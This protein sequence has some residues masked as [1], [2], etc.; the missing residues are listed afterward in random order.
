MTKLEKFQTILT[1]LKSL[2]ADYI[3]RLISILS[4]EQLVNPKSVLDYV[5][6]ERFAEGW[7]CPV[8][9]SKHIVRNGHRPK[10]N[11]QRFLCRDCGKSFTAN[12][13]SIS[14]G[15]RKNMLVWK[16]YI[17]CM[18]NGFSVRKTAQICEIHRNTAFAWRHK[19][20][21]AL[22][23][24]QNDV[25][26]S[27]IVEADETFFPVSYKGNHKN[28]KTF[29][30][31]R[32]PH[33]RGH[34]IKKKGLSD[35]QVC[36]PCAVNRKGKSIAKVGKLG[37]VSF[38]C[39]DIILG[40][41]IISNSTLCT[42]KEQAYRKFSREH[43]LQLIQLETGKSKRGIYNIQHINSYHSIL[44]SF[45]YGF[46]GVSTKYLNNYLVWNNLVNYADET[47]KEKMSIFLSYVMCKSIKIRYKDIPKRPPLPVVV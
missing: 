45:M 4:N 15:T 7:V 39:I 46:K 17:E 22:Q 23:F 29:V 24:M 33:H 36:V 37:K 26:L 44:K 40:N 30:M 10:N 3:D 9:E 27:G 14:S 16:K 21:D 2:S 8:C 32:E 25:S 20:L 1:L 28:S 35:E 34:S 13:N 12:T 42:D 38:N 11:A 47:Y 31:P 18:M 43:N 5:N 41:Q 19:V 6:N